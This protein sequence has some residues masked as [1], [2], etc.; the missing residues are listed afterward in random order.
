MKAPSLSKYPA[1][2][3]FNSSRRGK[4][5]KDSR[6]LSVTADTLSGDDD[7][8]ELSLAPF[9]NQIV[10]RSGSH[11]HFLEAVFF[12]LSAAGIGTLNVEPIQQQLSDEHLFRK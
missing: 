11:L 8:F 10:R 12:V 1:T 6:K 4:E 2:C 9:S 3:K 5:V 7:N